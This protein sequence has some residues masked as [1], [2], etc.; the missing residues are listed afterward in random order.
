MPAAHEG[1]ETCLDCRMQGARAGAPSQ[2]GGST[3][4]LDVPCA[5][6]VECSLPHRRPTSL[7]LP[8]PMLAPSFT[9]LATSEAK[10]RASVD[11]VRSF[12]R[13][14]RREANHA[15][16]C[17]HGGGLQGEGSMKH[18]KPCRDP[19]PETGSVR[20]SSLRAGVPDPI[21]W[22]SRSSTQHHPP[23]QA[24]PQLQNSQGTERAAYQTWP[25]I[26]GACNGSKPHACCRRHPAHREGAHQA[27]KVLS[28]SFCERGCAARGPGSDRLTWAAPRSNH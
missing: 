24:A 16:R 8:T 14:Q 4:S 1:S 27:S 13:S 12:Q 6:R 19:L 7:L 26:T 15:G 5:P 10:Y 17:F 2:G 11:G 9:I 18:K 22:A 21:A 20:S 23:D 25:L 28:P 3:R